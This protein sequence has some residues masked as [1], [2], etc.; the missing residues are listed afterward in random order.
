M[1]N[2]IDWVERYK[3]M[4]VGKSYFYYIPDAVFRARRKRYLCNAPTKPEHFSELYF[5][6][7]NEPSK[8]LFRRYGDIMPS[9]VREKWLRRNS[10]SVRGNNL[11]NNRV[12]LIDI[13]YFLV[14]PPEKEEQI[15]R[16]F[17]LRLLMLYLSVL[18][19]PVLRSG[20]RSNYIFEFLVPF[21]YKL[22]KGARRQVVRT[23]IAANDPSTMPKIKYFMMKNVSLIDGDLLTEYIN[24][25]C[26]KSLF[27]PKTALGLLKRK[28]YFDQNSIDQLCAIVLRMENGHQILDKVLYQKQR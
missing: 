17:L 15:D 3:S 8:N 10:V 1:E 2:N 24:T 25:G 7:S 14:V 16:G 28:Q 27:A 18:N 22:K 13:P 4:V 19:H 12:W 23:L 21:F 26:Q 11:L 5:I 6:F 9:D 20:K